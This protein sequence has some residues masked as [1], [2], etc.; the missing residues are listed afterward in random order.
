[1]DSIEDQV[2]GLRKLEPIEAVDRKLLSPEELR[3]HI[4]EDF[5]KD[6]TTEEA[7]KDALILAALGLLPSGFEL[8]DFYI[9]LLTEQVAG[10]YDDEDKAMYVV[11]GEGFNGPERL[12]YSHEYTHALQD[13]HYDFNDSLGY[14]DQ[15]CEANSER[16]A[17]IQALIEGDA[18]VLEFQ[19]FTEHSTPDDMREIQE[20]YANNQSPVYDSAPAFIKEDL[21][22]PYQAGQTFVEQIF[23]QGGWEAVDAVFGNPPLST[24][25]ILHPERYPDDKPVDVILPDLSPVL[26]QGWSELDRSV[27]GEWFTYLILAQGLEPGFR[28]DDRTARQAAE[29]WG[30]NAYVFYINQD[31]GKIVMALS[32]SWDSVSEARQFAAA[33]RRYATARFGDP[34]ASQNSYN[35]WESPEGVH[36]FRLDTSRTIWI[37]A[38]DAPQAEAIW[39]ILE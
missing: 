37:L 11:Q 6:Y 25:Q 4:Q 20:F 31:S 35:A 27:M 13:Q 33:F 28:L 16:C 30:G 29:G 12:T 26:G 38:V 23:E 10:F 7:D 24:E 9:E 34:S 2:V 21:I 32:T 36:T 1:M 17:A 3:R 22:F 15:A 8:R 19:W 14:N 39:Q 5:L 18:T